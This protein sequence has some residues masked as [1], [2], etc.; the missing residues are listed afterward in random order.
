[1]DFVTGIASTNTSDLLTG[2]IAGSRTAIFEIILAASVTFIGK[3]MMRVKHGPDGYIET[4]DISLILT[5]RFLFAVLT[6]PVVTIV[7]LKT[8]NFF[9]GDFHWQDPVLLGELRD[10]TIGIV[11]FSPL[12]IG[13]AIYMTG[14]PWLEPRLRPVRRYIVLYVAAAAILNLV[15]ALTDI[16]KSNFAIEIS[17]II[18]TAVG[19]I[20]PHAIL[21]GALQLIATTSIL[22][23]YALWQHS[24]ITVYFV[25]PALS[26]TTIMLITSRTLSQV[27]MNTL[28][29]QTQQQGELLN[30]FVRNGPHYFLVEDQD[31]KVIEISEAFARDMFGATADEMIGHDSLDFRTWDPEAVAR[32]R[33]ARIQFAQKL[34]GG[35]ILS[36]EY[37]TKTFDGQLLHLKAN[38]IHTQ[39]PTGDVHRY[40]VAQDRTDVVNANE[41]LRQ[42]AYIDALTG[43]RNR[44]ALLVDFLGDRD[45]RD[46]DYGLFMCRIDSLSTINE[47]Y[48]NH[49]GDRY[50]KSVSDLLRNEMGDDAAVYRLGGDIFMIVQHWDGETPSLEFAETLQ[51]LVGG[52]TINVDGH[53]V[54]QSITIGIAK[55]PANQDFNTALNLCQRALDA[56]RAAGESQIQIANDK[57]IRLLDAQGAFVTQRDVEDALENGEFNYKMQPIVDI[58]TATIAGVDAKVN[59]QRAADAHL[60]FDAYRDHFLEIVMKQSHDDTL[61]TMAQELL[62]SA[63]MAKSPCVYW[64][65][66]SKLLENDAIMHRIAQGFGKHPDVSM[67]LAFPAKSLLARTSRSTVVSNLHHLRDAGVTVAIDAANLDDTNVL[68]IAQLPIDEIILSGTI[69]EDISSD[70]RMQYRVAPI[71]DLLRKFDIKLAAANVK[72]QAQLQTVAGLG[73]GY[74]SGDIFA[75]A[76][77]PHQY[78]TLAQT[79]EIETLVPE[80][81]NIVTFRDFTGH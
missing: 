63:I 1:M 43:L 50:L 34:T 36:H 53:T 2:F 41:K 74:C 8:A 48:S 6:L 18:M 76:V 46:K 78:P 62:K 51:E 49:A 16:G 15:F 13:T 73:I 20:F 81:N 29:H 57:F 27:K 66:R 14:G 11:A 56:A 44:P 23:Q 68:Q 24:E 39:T 7:F 72:T 38:Y 70:R 79:L 42:Q 59:W 21:I 9:M 4:F 37:S 69:I 71:V 52:F 80:T 65:T 32:I 17:F 77:P 5:R 60:S 19:F 31:F 33:N 67:A 28:V 25:I 26:L 40:V 75:Q 35:D 12:G 55:L 22:L 61:A 10:Y 30:T 64:H 58:R 47:A 3:P 54:R 45:L